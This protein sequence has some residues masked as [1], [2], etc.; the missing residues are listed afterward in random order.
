MLKQ[1]QEQDKML[2]QKQNEFLKQEEKK[3]EK[4]LS[5]RDAVLKKNR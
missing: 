5:T 1:K 3:I 2:Q 4:I